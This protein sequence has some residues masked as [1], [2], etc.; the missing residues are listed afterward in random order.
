MIF[1]ELFSQINTERISARLNERVT[2]N[3][4]EQAEAPVEETTNEDF[5]MVQL[6]NQIEQINNAGNQDIV[7]DN[8]ENGEQN[9]SED[10]LLQLI[11]DENLALY[12][13]TKQ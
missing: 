13:K 6:E 4:E 9:I 8:N 11:G 5:Q 10:R 2:E 7:E 3:V 12:K 1:I